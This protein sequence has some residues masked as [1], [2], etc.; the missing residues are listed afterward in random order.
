[1][2]S[3]GL[4]SAREGRL[5]LFT[6][7]FRLK[8]QSERERLRT[9]SEIAAQ[10]MD[11]KRQMLTVCFMEER[12]PRPIVKVSWARLSQ[13]QKCYKS[14]KSNYEFVLSFQLLFGFLRSSDCKKIVQWSY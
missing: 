6:H 14:P 8:G 9:L 4:E 13:L 7:L 12:D 5:I 10:E 1:M 2:L 3:F 11:A